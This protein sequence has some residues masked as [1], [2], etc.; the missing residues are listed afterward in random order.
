[1]EKPLI[2][3]VKK[4]SM[5][6]PGLYDHNQSRGTRRESGRLFIIWDRVDIKGIEL[7]IGPCQWLNRLFSDRMP[8]QAGQGWWDMIRRWDEK[9]PREQALQHLYRLI[10]H[11]SLRVL[12]IIPRHFPPSILMHHSC[13]SLLLFTLVLTPALI[14]QTKAGS[15]FILTSLVLL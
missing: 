14:V 9:E 11:N 13:F 3:N 12:S 8:G 2:K 10:G 15:L 4:L 5:R 6:Y 7:G 1:M